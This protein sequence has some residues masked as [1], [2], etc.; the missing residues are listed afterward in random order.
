MYLRNSKVVCIVYDI[1][2]KETFERAKELFNELKEN[3]VENATICLIGN[4]LDLSELR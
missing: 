4:K 3:G 1:T 2:S